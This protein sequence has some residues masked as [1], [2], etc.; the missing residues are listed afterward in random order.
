M[1]GLWPGPLSIVLPLREANGLSAAVLAGQQS[2]A[3]RM[4]NHP[5]AQALLQACD[6]PLAVTSANASGQL[7]ATTAHD[8]ACALPE[9]L[10]LADQTQLGGIES[11]LID[12][13]GATP[14]ILRHGAVT[15]EQINMLIGDV[16]DHV[17]EVRKLALHTPLRLNAVDVKAGEAFLGFGNVNYI[18]VEEIGFVRDMPEQQWRNLSVSGDLDEAAKNFYGMLSALDQLHAK[19]IAVMR[20][21]EMG[22]GIALNDK[23]RRAAKDAA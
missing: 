8:V 10:V 9:V 15:I 12:L 7:S 21:P 13:T 23:L 1:H 20:L 5:V 16:E 2:V 18:G 4:P 17:Q 14:K 3:L 19:S 22:L 6:L 11:T